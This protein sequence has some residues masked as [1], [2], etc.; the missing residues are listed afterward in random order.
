MSIGTVRF[1]LMLTAVPIA[2]VLTAIATLVLGWITTDYITSFAISMTFM[3]GITFGI[4]TNLTRLYFQHVLRAEDVELTVREASQART[5]LISTH[6]KLLILI[7][8][9]PVSLVV[10]PEGA[11]LP[12]NNK[13]VTASLAIIAGLAGLA[14]SIKTTKWTLRYKTVQRESSEK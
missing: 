4:S 13:W 7:I 14:I 1:L 8:F 2:F 10:G 9:I 5:Q 3:L 12:I 6:L 11:N